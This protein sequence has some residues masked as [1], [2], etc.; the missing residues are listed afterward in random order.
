[1]KMAYDDFSVDS[2]MTGLLCEDPSLAVQSARDE[3]DI[4]T[5]VKR[6]GLSGQLP[7]DVRAPEY[8]DFLEVVDFQTAMNAIA[9]A[10]TAFMAMPADI[11]TRFG[12]DPHAFVD[13]CSDD[14]NLEEMKRLGLV[15]TKD[16]RVRVERTRDSDSTPVKAP[17]VK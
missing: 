11:R 16:R 13:F 9:T 4:N 6:F 17:E 5:I 8:A 10:N 3:A 1:M 15:V 2:F 14:D 12:N 7:T